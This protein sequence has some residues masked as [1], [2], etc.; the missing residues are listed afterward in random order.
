MWLCRW[1]RNAIEVALVTL[2][3]LF[4]CVLSHH[5]LLQ[6]TRGKVANSASVRL[7]TW[8]SPFVMLQIAWL[9]WSKVTFITLQLCGFSPV[10]FIMWT[11]RLVNWLAEKL[12]CV[13]LCGFSPVWMRKWVFKL[14]FWLNDLLQWEQVYLLP[15]LWLCL[16]LERLLEVAKLLG[17]RSQDF[18]AAIFDCR[19]HPLTFFPD[20]CRNKWEH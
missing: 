13:H 6:F 2:V 16:W 12:Q 7:F 9:N 1:R 14:V 18:R 15:P 19:C 10:C 5:V 17:H 11:L 4:S 20:D 3:W 8:V